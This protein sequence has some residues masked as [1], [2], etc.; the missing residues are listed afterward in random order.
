MTLKKLLFYFILQVFFLPCFCQLQDSAK[1]TKNKKIIFTVSATA[2]AAGSLTYLN[3]IWYKPY[4]TSNFHFYNDNAEWLQM[5]K[6]GHGWT[7]YNSACW[8]MQAMKACGFSNKKSM[9]IGESIG[10]G[11][12]T[13]VEVM[14]GFS[15][16]WGFSWGDMA[17]N[18]TGSSLA[19]SQQYF[20]NEQ[21]I[22]LKYSFHQTYFA[23]QRP[24]ELGSNLLEE[25]I[26]DYN[27]QTYWLSVN[28]ASFLKKETKF[29]KWL[30]V[31]FGYGATNMVSGRSN[32]IINADKSISFGNP[33]SQTSE[34]INSNGS[35]NYFTRY[36]KYYFSLDIDFTKIKTKSKILGGIFSVI[37]CL[38]IPFP[39]IEISKKGFGFYPI[40]N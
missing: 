5:D 9:L 28:V 32:E 39:S 12:E 25:T 22:R 4:T 30:N 15:S 35:I 1:K 18:F 24:N 13:I 27:G 11:Y 20:W 16:G 6:C 29:P 26:K 14:D 17:A 8:M 7:T 34:I 37:N 33:N 19:L 38:K 31:A 3:Q 23:A 36:R 40:Y 21:R 2:I 10:F